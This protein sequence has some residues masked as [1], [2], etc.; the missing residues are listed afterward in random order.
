MV[1][2]EAFNILKCEHLD[3]IQDAYDDALFEYKAKFLQQIPP[4]KLI[5][6]IMKKIVRV[7][8]AYHV[9]Y[10]DDSSQDTNTSIVEIETLDVF[11]QSYQT[12]LSTLR[13]SITNALSGDHLLEGINELILHQRNLFRLLSECLGEGKLDIDQ[14]PIKLSEEI[15]VFKLQLE[16]KALGLDHTKISE[17]IRAQINDLDFEEFAYVT[18]AVINAE[19]QMIF[20]GI[21]RE[22]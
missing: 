22:V 6:G 2:E 17:Y 4:L 16:L 15:D 21:S 19:K 20:N 7:N 1:K 10:P 13:L 14:Y 3:G 18:Q 12:T 9:F 8:T 11:L 5:E